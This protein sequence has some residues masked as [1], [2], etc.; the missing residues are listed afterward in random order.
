[1][2]YIKQE[3]NEQN[4][5]V[6]PLELIKLVSE[7]LGFAFLVFDISGDKHYKHLIQEDGKCVKGNSRVVY[8]RLNFGSS[9]CISN[10]VTI[11][12][13][14]CKYPS[15]DSSI[16]GIVSNIESI[17]TNN[18]WISTIYGYKY[19]WCN[20]H[21]I[22]SADENGSS[23]LSQRRKGWK[24]GDIISMK[25]DRKQGEITW[26]LNKQEQCKMKLEKAETYHCWLTF[27][28]LKKMRD[29]EYR[30]L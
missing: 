18:A 3:I 26:Y 30:L 9:Y 21:G 19:W 29:T 27:K 25:I 2:G 22:V 24:S 11:I 17:Y 6:Y 13:I 5:T 23:T 1:M 20:K 16:I 15:S 4:N 7:F 8:P 12:H 14:A 28:G 10:D